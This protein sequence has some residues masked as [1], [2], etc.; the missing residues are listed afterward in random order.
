MYTFL[1]YY[2]STI[3]NWQTERSVKNMKRT[4]IGGQAVIEGVMMRGR[5]EYVMAV[6]TP[7]KDIMIEKKDVLPISAKF[8]LF[9]LPIFRGM[10]AFV[11]SMIMGTK[12][13]MRS[14]EI[15][16]EETEE[17]AKEEPSK[18][19]KFLEAKFG[20]KLMDYMIYVSVFISMMAAIG[21]FMLLP[22]WIGSFFKGF[23]PG[24]WALSIVEGLVRIGI[25][26][27][28]LYAISK[29]KEIKRLFQYHGAEHKTINCFE[30][31]QDLTVENVKKHTRLH[32]RCGT[33]FL[34]LVMIISMVVFFF[35][36]T[37][38]IWLRFLSRIVLVPFVAGI[39]YEVLKWAGSSDSKLVAAVSYPGLCLQKVT[40]AEPED[41]QIETAI[42]ALK[43]VLEN[44]PA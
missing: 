3:E 39:S 27:L 42:A 35:V 36:S 43:G 16:G 22:V 1:V 10:A 20:D 19:E 28:Y 32:K 8:G 13:I 21:L 40:T 23:L 4:S 11:D 41:D 24:V 29:M 33:S 7:N 30:S 44:E 37:D 26:L 38:S 17:E 15:A 25:F 9:K 18:F 6:R 12:I 31:E 5:K 34:F 14:A 2:S